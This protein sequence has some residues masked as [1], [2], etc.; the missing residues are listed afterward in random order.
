[1]E[2]RPILSALSRNRMGAMLILLQVALTLAIV[3]NALFIIH[4]RLQRMQ[5]PSGLDEANIVVVNNFWINEG[6]DLKGRL[7]RDLAALRALPDV[8][9]AVATRNLPLSNSGWGT[10]INLQPD[11]KTDSASVA[12]YFVDEHGLDALGIRIVSGRWFTPEEIADRK[13]GDQSVAPTIIIT[14]AL[15]NKLFADGSALGKLVYMDDTPTTIVGII[16]RMQR[17][18]VT[19]DAAGADENSVLMPALYQSRGI[20]YVLRARPGRSAAVLQ[21]AQKKLLEIDRLRMIGQHQTRPFAEIRAEAYE[22]DSALTAILSVVCLLLL[23]VTALGI[24]GLSSYWV[25]QRRRQIGIRRALG[26]RRIDILRYF[27]TENLLIGGGGALLGA[28]AAI[29]LNL[30]LV[31]HYEMSRLPLPY[32]AAGALL[33]LGLGQLAVLGPALRATRVSPVVATRSA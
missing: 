21:A 24:V 12:V 4:E 25:S 31:T 3:C 8:V 6:D 13:R 23:A 7:Q 30:W 5:R 15:A 26:A 9:D 11:Q 32:V 10:G 17:P 33:V 22:G 28:A 2:I 27:Q 18:W 29:G 19:T 1:M 20:L 14:Q 16:E